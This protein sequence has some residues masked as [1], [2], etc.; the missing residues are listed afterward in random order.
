MKA[1]DY[2]IIGKIKY[3]FLALAI[4]LGLLFVAIFLGATI[5]PWCLIIC[6]ASPFI[7]LLY[8]AQSLIDFRNVE[9][10]IAENKIVLLY[11]NG[12]MDEISFNELELIEVDFKRD[13]AQLTSFPIKIKTALKQ[14]SFLFC[15]L[16]GET[17]TNQLILS[18]SGKT[19][20]KFIDTKCLFV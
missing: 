18:L 15:G 4:V 10:R 6:L 20:C 19:S 5:S 16:D 11:S 7:G 8:Q 13:F 9:I 3:D 1:L 12:S 14:Y 17:N 2:N